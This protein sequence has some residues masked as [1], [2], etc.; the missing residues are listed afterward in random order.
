MNKFWRFLSHFLRAQK[1]WHWP[2]QSD[3]MI[4]D[5]AGQDVLLKHL[6]PW[7]PVVLHVRGEEINLPVAL[8]SLFRAGRRFDAYV[9]RYIDSVRPRLIVTFTDNDPKF[10]SLV[11]RHR[12]IKT[13][14]VQNGARG[15]DDVFA[16]LDRIDRS[17]EFLK[18]DYMMTF[19]NCIGAEYAKKIDGAVVPMGSLKNNMVP[20]TQAKKPGTIAYISQY[21]NSTPGA[22]GGRLV[23]REQFSGQVD[24]AALSFLVRYAEA[25]GRSLFIIPCAHLASEDE[26]R[27]ER[28]YYHDLVGQ[29]VEFHSG[30]SPFT[31][32]DAVDSAEVVVGIDS[33]LTYESAARGNRT[34]F[35]SIRG[36][37]LGIPNSGYGWPEVYPPEGPFWSSRPDPAAFERVL[38]HLFAISDAQWKAELQAHGFDNVII[39][40]AGN[41]ILRSILQQELG[42]APMPR[43]RFQ[44]GACA[45]QSTVL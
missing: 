19:G 36:E 25:R 22:F 45:P 7:K 5:A 4:L 29:A 24:R 35:F 28:R 14:F 38:D 41:G 26:Q 27:E 2:R 43:E 13:L 39:Y 6:G 42:A 44:R 20:R 8:A 3:V 40:D 12:G 15:Y 10:Y 32:Y 18:V 37:M 33:T 34:A 17:Q 9:D 31:S 30:T 1:R 23:T 16:A 11:A 21:R